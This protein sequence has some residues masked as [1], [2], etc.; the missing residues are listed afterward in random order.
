M[1]L[2]RKA[3]GLALPLAAFS[4]AAGLSLAAPSTASAASVG[5]VRCAHLS[6]NAPKV[7]VYLYSFNSKTPP[8]VLKGVGYGDVSEY[9]QFEAGTYTVAM[10]PAGAPSSTTPIV[11][12]AITVAPGAA[13]T[14]AG[15]GPASGLRLQ[16][17]Q[18]QLT[19]PPGQALVR[20]IQASLQEHKV[21]VT[22]GG[23][24]LAQQLAFPSV[25]GYRAI[26]PG[27]QT[28]RV[29]GG[30]EKAS[31][32]FDLSADTIHTLVVLDNK[33][34]GGLRIVSLVDAAGSHVLPVGGA[35]TGLGGTAPRAPGESALPWLAS[36][37]GGAMLALAGVA[38]L[39]WIR[40]GAARVP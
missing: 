19:T 13:Y 9:M 15:V 7:D 8:M 16:A 28:V 17:M 29:T 18:D 24:V 31:Q 37:A 34:S 22:A 26:S 11:S 12:T 3:L 32:T 2:P 1:K 10:R 35:A 23:Q 33:T 5:W 20:V 4:L 30:S 40:D 39:R 21:T 25:T 36:I 6:P 38:R 27:D 14:V